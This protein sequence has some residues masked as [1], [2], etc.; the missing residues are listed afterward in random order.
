MPG[1]YDDIINLAHHVSTKRA[2][3][4]MRDRAAQFSPFAALTG[5]DE[6]IEETAR[7]TDRKVEI[8]EKTKSVLNDKLLFIGENINKKPIVVIT[9]FLDDTLKSGGAYITVEG[10]VRKVDNVEKTVIM[11][12]RRVIPICD[13]CDI[14]CELFTEYVRKLKQKS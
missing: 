4:S 13:I 14:D 8:D 10:V 5:H 1:K 7:L 11:A 12:D 2:R 9:Y 6:A 3:M